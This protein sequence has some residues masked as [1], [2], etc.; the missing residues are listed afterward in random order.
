LKITGCRPPFKKQPDNNHMTVQKWN[1]KQVHPCV[2]DFLTSSVPLKS[3]SP[4][5][6]NLCSRQMRKCCARANKTHSRTERVFILEHYFASKSFAAVREAL[7]R[8]YSDKYR[9]RRNTPNRKDFGTQEITYM[10]VTSVQWATKQLKLPL[11]SSA[12]I[13]TMRCNCNNSILPLFSSFCAWT[14]FTYS[15][16]GCI[17]DGTLCV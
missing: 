3:R 5:L 9:I 16:Q 10:S 12:P 11:S 8:A 13:V 1:Q 7:S 6:L 17:L 2:I 15:S 14:W 4:W